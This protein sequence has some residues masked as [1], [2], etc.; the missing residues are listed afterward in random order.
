MATYA[1][2]GD[3]K[4]VTT[5]IASQTTRYLWD[6]NH[7]LPQLAVEQ[8]SVGGLLR[9]YLYGASRLSMTAGGDTRY[10][11]YDALGSVANLTSSS[12]AAEWTYAYEP[13]GTVQTETQDDPSAPLNLMKFAGE[14]IDSTGLYHLRAR[15][16]DPVLG[17]FLG[18]DPVF[19]DPLSPHVSR[20]AYAD[21]R[22][23]VMIDPSGMR[24]APPSDGQ[25]ASASA[26]SP[27][28]CRD[29][30]VRAPARHGKPNGCG[31]GDWRGDV[32]PEWFK[33]AC[34]KHDL[35][36]GTWGKVRRICDEQFK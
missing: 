21:N 2:D 36:Y 34:D 28:T 35:C 30:A 19:P 15:Q 29:F 23:T 22:P 8:D 31:P 6:T 20:Y 32:T 25:D 12:G 33:G 16:Y 26:A 11:H 1:Y 3:G 5:S 18:V 17:R 24:A 14:L 4:R 7:F 9:R 10:Y 27:A 13:Y